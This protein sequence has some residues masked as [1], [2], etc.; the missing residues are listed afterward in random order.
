MSGEARLGPVHG[1]LASWECALETVKCCIQVSRV[2]SVL[3]LWV[4]PLTHSNGRSVPIGLGAWCEEE[5]V[6]RYALMSERDSFK[7]L[8]GTEKMWQHWLPH[9]MCWLQ[10]WLYPGSLKMP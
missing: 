5:F 2:V 1:G 3:L 10:T 6:Q 7:G 4:R 8:L 9:L